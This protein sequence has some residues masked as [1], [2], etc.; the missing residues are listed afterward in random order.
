[1]MP[2]T[3][4]SATGTRRPHP[5]CRSQLQQFRTVLRFYVTEEGNYGVDLFIT[6]I[7]SLSACQMTGRWSQIQHVAAAQQSFGSAFVQY[8]AAVH[9]AG[10]LE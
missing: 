1:M 5:S 3:G 2:R 7:R 10:Y 8:D 4:I 6:N 9:L